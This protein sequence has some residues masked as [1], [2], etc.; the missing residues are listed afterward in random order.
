MKQDGFEWEF[1]PSFCEECGG[2]CCTGESGYIWID[3]GESR[4]LAEHLGLNEDEFKEKFLIKVGKKFS[5][6]EKSHED[7]YACVFFDEI[8]KNCSIYEFRPSQCRSFPFWDYFRKNLR[9]LERECIGV[10]FL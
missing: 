3:E 4:L 6:K 7:G 5:I 2:K 9:E 8:N 1:D 10:K